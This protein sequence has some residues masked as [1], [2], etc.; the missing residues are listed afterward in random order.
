MVDRTVYPPGMDLPV[1]AVRQIFARCKVPPDVCIKIA[2]AG[3]TTVEMIAVMGE[4][5]S[6]VRSSL[7]TLRGGDTLVHADVGAREK[8][9]LWLLAV[10][11]ACSKLH[12]Q[13]SIRRAKMEEDPHVIPSIQAEDLCDYRSRFVVD[14]PDVVLLDT[15]EPHKKFVERV[16][17]DFSL[18]QH[19]PAFEVGEI[20]RR[21]ETI[22]SKSGMA[23]TA[24]MLVKMVRTD[25]DS[26][27]VATEEEVMDRINAFFVTLEF[28][29]ICVFNDKDGP[30]TYVRRLSEHR[31]EAPG[32]QSLLIA[33]KLIRK[34]V[35]RL[36][37][38]ERSRFPTFSS[39][40]L[41]VI[42]HCQWIWDKA[43]AEHDRSGRR[44]TKEFSTPDPKK[45][46]IDDNEETEK[47]PSTSKSKKRRTREKALIQEAKK[48]L[49][50]PLAQ[51][52]GSSKGKPATANGKGGGGKGKKVP[53]DVFNHV[54]ANANGKCVFF[55]LGKCKFGDDCR[56][57]HVCSECGGP[58]SYV[59]AHTGQ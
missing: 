23:P 45:R 25:V 55:N 6:S 16:S 54:K 4:N 36:N 26:S 22:I 9:F 31:R 47:E 39:G 34:E 40:L 27:E 56:E 57:T 41:F 11:S 14:H 46:R 2:G 35:F 7:T 53:Q 30:L 29:S 52:K 49:A 32:L 13:Q 28:L 59:S 58:H 33:D 51:G 42:N 10:W 38:D 17:R 43:R 3:L 18:N 8:I 12:A 50:K 15:R 1:P 19:V 44:P 48:L 37:T 20:R 5:H 24:D 21:S